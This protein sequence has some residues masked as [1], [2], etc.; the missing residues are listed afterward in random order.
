MLN[1]LILIGHLG[2]DPELRYSGEG[3]PIARFRLAVTTRLRQDQGDEPREETEWFTV[4]AFGRQ[5]EACVQSLRKGD[6]VFVEGRLRSR[7]FR[8]G[9]GL[10]RFEVQVLARRLLFLSPGRSQ[11]ATSPGREIAISPGAEEEA[12]FEEEP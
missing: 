6:R 11:E 7:S 8:G 12:F 3:R 2:A 4:L 9:D 5:A 1:K 10:P